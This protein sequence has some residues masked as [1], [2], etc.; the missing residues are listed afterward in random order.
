MTNPPTPLPIEQPHTNHFKLINLWQSSE[1]RQEK[2]HL[3]RSCG[4]NN[5]W[6]RRMRDWRLSKIERLY[7]LKP[8]VTDKTLPPEIA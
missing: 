1:E 4:A 5:S 3:A 6:A 8:T 2:Y 7:N